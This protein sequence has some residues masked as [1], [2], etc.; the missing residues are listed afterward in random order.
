[1][2]Y[3]LAQPLPFPTA[4]TLAPLVDW[5]REQAKLSADPARP[6]GLTRLAAELVEQVEQEAPGLLGTI[7]DYNRQL[8]DRHRDL[9]EALLT[10]LFPPAFQD[11]ALSGALAPYDRFVFAATPRFRQVMCNAAGML[12]QPLNLAPAETN[13]YLTRFA[14]MLVLGKFYGVRVPR[15]ETIIFTVPDYELGLYR[16][17]KVDIDSRFLRVVPRGELPA[18]SAADKRALVGN[19]S[20]LQLWFE[21]L[22]PGL[23]ELQGFTVLNL[24]DVTEQQVLSTL[25]N[26]LL[27]RDVLLASDRLEQLQE[28]LRALFRLPTLRFGLAAYRRKRGTFVNFGHQLTQQSLSQQLERIRQGEPS[29]QVGADSLTAA[30]EF[31]RLYDQLVKSRKPLVIEDVRTTHQLPDSLREKVLEL[32]I[33]NAILCLLQYGDDVLGVLELGSPEPGALTTFSLE[34][35]TPF[36]PLFAVAVHRHQESQEARVQAIVKERFTA[37]HPALEWKFVEAAE[38]YLEQQTRGVTTPVLRPV[39]FPDVYPLYGAV[40]V[41]G[42]SVARAEAIRADLTEHLHLANRVLNLA[43]EY[44]PL[45]IV[46]ELRFSVRRY[47]LRLREGLNSEEEISILEALRTEVEPLLEYLYSNTPDLRPAIQKYWAA[48]DPKLGFL[49]KRRLAFEQSLTKINETVSALVDVEEAKAQQMYPHYF[50]KSVTDGVEFDIYVGQS[51]VEKASFD[52][53]FLRNLRLWQLLLLVRVAQTTHALKATLP[54]PL[55]TTQLLLINTQ[56]LSVRFREDERQFDVDGAYNVRYEIIKKRIDKATVEGTG[57]R[58][59]QPGTIALVYAQAREAT[60]YYEY[61]DYLR[62]RNLLLPDT[63]HLTLEEAQGVSGLQALRVRVNTELPADT[64]SQEETPQSP[65]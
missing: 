38:D 53:I 44:Q 9:V 48:I 36:L 56:P 54:V 20:D 37:I 23:F 27:E 63:E 64:T 40:D 13:F 10:V 49:Y 46:D 29:E 45:P 31:H 33:Q 34:K 1:M 15:E 25:K 28:Q 4:L 18:L 24:T 5:W 59:T 26:D 47:L 62:A 39:I 55:A 22:P 52:P 57:E 11:T 50:R 32:G 17:Y 14:Y 19:L 8:L 6:R 7:T 2:D 60:E 61:L 16:H 51:L 35:I 12:K 58:L 43:A 41:R 3:H 21:K 65:A 42:S 30:N